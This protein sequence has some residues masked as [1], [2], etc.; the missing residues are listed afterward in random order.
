MTRQMLFWITETHDAWKWIFDHDSVPRIHQGVYRNMESDV[1][2]SSLWDL[3]VTC[4]EG[5]KMKVNFRRFYIR[6]IGTRFQITECHVLHKDYRYHVA[7]LKGTLEIWQYKCRASLI[8]SA[9][10]KLCYPF[11]QSCRN[12]C[13]LCSLFFPSLFAIFAGHFCTAVLLPLTGISQI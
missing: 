7:S 1:S 9:S 3:N 4:I 2:L 6:S 13:T 8:S 5:S 11:L 10:A 12:E